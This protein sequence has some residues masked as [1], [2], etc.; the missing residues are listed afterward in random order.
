M[1]KVCDSTRTTTIYWRT[2]AGT[3][4][5]E[6]I[7]QIPGMTPPYEDPDC[8]HAFHIYASIVDPGEAGFTNHELAERL[9]HDHGVQCFPGLYRPSY[10]FGLYRRRGFADGQC[11]VA[12]RAAANALQLPLSPQVTDEQVEYVGAALLQA[13]QTLRSAAVSA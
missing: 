9:L 1:R 8:E 13:A 10:Q 11:P 4:Y 7:E 12:E 2:W 3:S 5:S 6:V